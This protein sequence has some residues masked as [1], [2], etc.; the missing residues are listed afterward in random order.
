MQG[1]ARRVGEHICDDET[2]LE[3]VLRPARRDRRAFA[4]LVSLTA[5]RHRPLRSQPV[6]GQ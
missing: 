5:R 1:S 6:F 3:R 2:L 4:R